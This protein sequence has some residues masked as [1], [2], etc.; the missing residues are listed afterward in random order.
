MDPNAKVVIFDVETTGT[1]AERDQIIELCIQTSLE[2]ES[3][4]QTWRFKPSVPI[5]P[6]AQAVHG[7][8][9]E[10]VA[11]CPPFSAHVD[12]IR[13]IVE[14][15]DVLVGY[16]LTFDLEFLSAEV[17]R[18][19]RPALKVEQTLLVDP[20]QIWRHFEPRNLGAAH[21]RFVG[22][23]FDGA[24]SATADVA[25]TGRVLNGM[26]N[27]FNIADKSWKEVAELCPIQTRRKNWVG[28]TH[29]L[30]WRN[31]QAVFG[32]GKHRNR[33]VIEVAQ[34]D[35]GGYVEWMAKQDFPAHVIE[36]CRAAKEMSA[37]DFSAWL[38]KKFSASSK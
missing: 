20:Y 1:S 18:S 3:Q 11:N 21:Q 33:A 38:G 30:Q 12:E 24:H 7:I 8:S 26:L 17:R 32:F 36:V 23:E 5:S 15:A 28:P 31:R 34:E 6:E 35:N 14:S 9:A 13:E 10:D 4:T 16:N 37:Q 2:D 29:H 27:S 25:A 22:S 19:D